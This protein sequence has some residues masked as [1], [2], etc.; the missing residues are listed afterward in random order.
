MRPSRERLEL[1]VYL[2]AFGVFARNPTVMP[3]SVMLGGDCIRAT[4][5]RISVTSF[6]VI[7][8][9][10]AAR[11]GLI[12]PLTRFLRQARH[13]H[14]VDRKVPGRPVRYSA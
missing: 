8:N 1:L 9:V 7:L 2:R 5:S 3:R 13:A 6:D 14:G 12:Y 11:P 10:D 4:I